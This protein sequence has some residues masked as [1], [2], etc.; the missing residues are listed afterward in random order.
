M[1]SKPRKGTRLLRWVVF[2]IVA[3]L[4]VLYIALPI[5]F[6]IVAVLPQRAPVGAPP[7]G[8]VDC[9][10]KTTDGLTLAGWYIPPANGTAI[11]LIHGAAARAKGCVPTPRCSGATATACWRWT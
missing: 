3:A 8:F 5:G 7:A 9:T 4:V 10:L 2:V 6:A 1:K 11:I